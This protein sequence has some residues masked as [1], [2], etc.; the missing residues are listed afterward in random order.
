MKRLQEV[1]A[2]E[3]DTKSIDWFEWGETIGCVNEKWLTYI[4]CKVTD[5]KQQQQQQ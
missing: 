4:C 3:M 2:V 1:P 5:Q